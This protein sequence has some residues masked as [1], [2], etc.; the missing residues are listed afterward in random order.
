[1]TSRLRVEII[2]TDPRLSLRYATEHSAAVDL[3]AMID[4]P[5]T[6]EPGQ[7]KKIGAGFRMH[8]QLPPGQVVTAIIAP[9]SGLGSKGLV[10]GNTIGII[11]AD[12][13]GEVGL[14][15]FNSG[16][17][18][19]TIAPGERIMQMLFVPVFQAS[20]EIVEAFSS[21]TA[22]GEGGFGSTGR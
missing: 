11:D 20:F 22:R 6:L 18:P 9:R 8:I 3:P 17:E 5:L 1:M 4:E 12:Y 2:P 7:R 15:L 19:L 10:I 21:I 13:Q 16:D 14:V